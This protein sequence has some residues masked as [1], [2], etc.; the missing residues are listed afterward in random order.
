MRRYCCGYLR[1]CFAGKFAETVA[2]D[3]CMMAERNEREARAEVLRHSLHTLI[4]EI[5]NEAVVVAGRV[6]RLWRRALVRVICQEKG[7]YYFLINMLL[8][9]QN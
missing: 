5:D 6:V 4:D 8:E 2:L 9:R 1:C 7:F 3:G